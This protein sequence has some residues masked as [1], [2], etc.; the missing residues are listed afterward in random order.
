M[1]DLKELV[2]LT[3]EAAYKHEDNIYLALLDGRIVRLRPEGDC[4]A[5]CYIAGATLTDALTVATVTSVE[6]L[7][8]V[9]EDR[10]YGDAIDTW[11][12]RIHTTRGT[13]TFDMR[14]EHN[15]YYGGTL[16][17]EFNHPPYGPLRGSPL[18]IIPEGAK[19]LEDW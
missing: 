14:V 19:P 12:H 7:E 10:S 18:T 4:C 16:K 1:S 3:V 6:D 5:W 17:V 2:G 13:C 9:Q 8:M 15:G 11:G